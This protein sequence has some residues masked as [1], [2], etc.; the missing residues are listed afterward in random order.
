MNFAVNSRFHLC[1]HCE[2]YF[3]LITVVFPAK[4]VCDD[5]L[6]GFMVR[7]S[8]KEYS[9]F[10][11]SCA[12]R[13]FPIAFANIFSLS[14]KITKSL[15]F[16]FKKDSAYW[17]TFVIFICDI[18]SRSFLTISEIILPTNTCSCRYWLL[19]YVLRIL[20][21][22]FDPFLIFCTQKKFR[23]VN[24]TNKRFLPPPLFF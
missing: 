1:R 2:V 23:H 21:L 20:I 24:L 4:N 9:L 10:S 8:S 16:L 18:D 7:I 12:S 19:M 17:A 5:Y 6:K 15:L 14:I 13:T 3:Y 22:V 11:S